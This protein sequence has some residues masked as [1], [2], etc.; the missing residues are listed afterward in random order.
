MTFATAYIH[1]PSFLATI[2]AL[3]IYA[4]IW[5]TQRRRTDGMNA[6]RRTL[7][8]MARAVSGF[9]PTGPVDPWILWWIALAL[10]LPLL[11]AR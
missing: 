7:G 11:L 8:R 5:I 10:L 2:L 1:H 4:M 3:N 9:P 6:L